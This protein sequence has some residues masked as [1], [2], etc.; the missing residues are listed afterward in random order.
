MQIIHL[1]VAS[2][3]FYAKMG[4]RRKSEEF[5]Y[6]FLFR[7]HILHMNNR[8]T[9]FW[10][11]FWRCINEIFS[12]FISIKI[13]SL[14][15]RRAFLSW[16]QNNFV[17]FNK[18]QPKKG[19]KTEIILTIEPLNEMIL[20]EWFSFNFILVCANEQPV[21]TWSVGKMKCL[22]VCGNSYNQWMHKCDLRN[23]FC[24]CSCSKA[25]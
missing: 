9:F 5:F 22:R 23:L 3:I 21:L 24:V 4:K 7:L 19:Q 13:S 2:F 20:L 14:S 12:R 10:H 15:C 17:V 8:L 18:R 11:S 1:S 16:T 25:K 6:L